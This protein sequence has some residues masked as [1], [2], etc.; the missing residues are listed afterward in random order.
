MACV[1]PDGSAEAGPET[2]LQHLERR[3]GVDEA[4][5][6]AVLAGW[7]REPRANSSRHHDESASS[8]DE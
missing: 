3:L 5:A 4:A 2:F 8:L 6:L 7:L 1:D